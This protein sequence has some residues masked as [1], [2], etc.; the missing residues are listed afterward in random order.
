MATRRPTQAAATPRMGE[1]PD[2]TATMER[3]NTE[4]DR[5][6]GEPR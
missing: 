1:E 6:S 5:S 2:S 4:K 3:P